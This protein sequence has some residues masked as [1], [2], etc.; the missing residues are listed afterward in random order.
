[1]VGG[2]PVAKADSSYVTTAEV[3]DDEIPD[4]VDITKTSPFIDGWVA[5]TLP[6]CWFL[7]LVFF[8]DVLAEMLKHRRLWT[9][10][11]LRRHVAEH[12]GGKCWRSSA[13][14][15]QLPHPSH[16]IPVQAGDLYAPAL[17]K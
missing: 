5:S 3:G 6:K 14:L 2:L 1:M 9:P 12:V 13:I 8:L 7:P 10:S 4:R 15:A 16:P 11:L 17:I